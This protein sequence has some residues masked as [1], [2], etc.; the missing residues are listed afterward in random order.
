[1]NTPTESR[2]RF[3][4]NY[5]WGGAYVLAKEAK[6]FCMEIESPL[7]TFYL[8]SAAGEAALL[9]RVCVGVCLEEL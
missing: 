3:S 8:R 9:S 6:A 1:V 7:V 5:E 4:V 2:S